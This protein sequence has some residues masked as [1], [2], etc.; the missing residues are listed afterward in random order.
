MPANDRSLDDQPEST[1][2][3]RRR[4]LLT[5]GIAFAG[6]AVL[7]TSLSSTTTSA[8]P[9]VQPG[10]FLQG[11]TLN[12]DYS[13][14]GNNPDTI[15]IL[16]TFGLSPFP[17]PVTITSAAVEPSPS[18][19]ED[20]TGSFTWDFALDPEI[21]EFAVGLGV[22]T[23]NITNGVNPISAT[24]GA[25]G[26]AA[27]TGAPAVLVDLTD[28]V[29]DGFTSGPYTGTF[30]RTAAVDAPIT[31]TPGTITSSVTTSSN[32]ALA[33]ICTPGA[34][35]I[36]VNDETGEAPSTTTTTRPPIVVPTTA[37]PPTTAAVGAGGQLPV[38]GASSSLYLALLGLGLVDV[39]Y[40]AMTAGKSSKRRASSAR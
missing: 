13:C 33:I 39:G 19:G 30:N 27:G 29:F 35:A 15:E 7:V 11:G 18:P 2:R 1:V 28:T 4:R 8:A 26:T 3:H 10:R 24:D 32:V 25:T 17:M 40:L 9:T 12:V 38:T 37:A 21:V 14:E 34:G 5:H 31:Y 23:F 22:T 36:T 6:A 20:Y 16:S